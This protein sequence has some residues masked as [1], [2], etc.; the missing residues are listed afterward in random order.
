MHTD[1][2][3][4]LFGSDV[5]WVLRKVGDSAFYVIMGEA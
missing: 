1:S 3:F 2:I 4:I 5:P